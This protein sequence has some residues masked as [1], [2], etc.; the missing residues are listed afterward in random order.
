MKALTQD[1]KE[2]IKAGIAFTIFLIYLP[3]LAAFIEILTTS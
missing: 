3:W 2:S 1:E